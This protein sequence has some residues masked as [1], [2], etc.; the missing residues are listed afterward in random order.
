MDIGKSISF[1]FEDKQWLPKILIGGLV[2]FGTILLSWTVIGLIIG[3]GLLLGYALEVLQNV[4]RGQAQ[5]LPEWDEWGDKAVKGI[6]LLVVYF[7]WSLPLL[8]FAVPSTLVSFLGNG[9]NTGAVI[10]L[11]MFCLSCLMFLYGILLTVLMPAITIKFAENESIADGFAFSDIF[12][13]TRENIGDIIIVVLVLWAVQIIA[14]IVGTILCLI[15]LLFTGFWSYLVQAHLFGQIGLDK[16]PTYADEDTPYDVSP[17]NV[18]PGVGELMEE[19]G[20]GAED[21]VVEVHDL[22]DSVLETGIGAT[23]TVVDQSAEV[24]S[25]DVFETL[26]DDSEQ[27]S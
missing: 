8:L 9:N 7:V 5:P 6:K 20:S 10:S 24:A 23:D 12:R 21:A 16:R 2:L 25:K 14:G 17:Q 15:G 3:I 11:L 22:G 13:F 1:V 18:M 19:V 26:P 27:T 4:R